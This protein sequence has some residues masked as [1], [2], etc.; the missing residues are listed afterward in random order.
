MR[1]LGR[2]WVGQTDEYDY[3]HVRMLG[4]FGE[5]TELKKVRRK[6]KEEEKKEKK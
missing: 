2:R 4:I 3:Y 5:Y 1:E 6:P